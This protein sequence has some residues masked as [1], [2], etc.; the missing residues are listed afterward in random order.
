MRTRKEN[1]LTR[2]NIFNMTEE[3]LIEYFE[4]VIAKYFYQ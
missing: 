1:K 4:H 3:E 2:K